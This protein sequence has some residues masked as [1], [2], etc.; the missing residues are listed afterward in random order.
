M[1]PPKFRWRFVDDALVATN[2]DDARRVANPRCFEVKNAFVET[3]GVIDPECGIAFDFHHK[4]AMQGMSLDDA[5]D[6]ADLSPGARRFHK[7]LTEDEDL[8][9][10][11]LEWVRRIRASR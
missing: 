6:D 10:L 3:L 8:M 2:A 1:H 11:Y 9:G 5:T 7:H 4:V